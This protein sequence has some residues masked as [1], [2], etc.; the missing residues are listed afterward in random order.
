ML[1]DRAW[2]Q[3]NLGFDPVTTPAPAST[4]A[5]PAGCTSQQHAGGLPAGD[6]R[7]RLRGTLREGVPRLHDGNRALDGSRIFRG[8]RGLPRRPAPNRAGAAAA[9]CHKPTCWW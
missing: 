1:T 3:R 8:R 4:F 6:D 2:V 9:H 5:V 7:I